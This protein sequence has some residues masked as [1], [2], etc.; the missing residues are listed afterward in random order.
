V[1]SLEGHGF[2]TRQDHGSTGNSGRASR[3]SMCCVERVRRANCGSNW[4][5]VKNPCRM[6]LSLLARVNSKGGICS[7]LSVHIQRQ[8]ALIGATLLLSASKP[9][10]SGHWEFDSGQSEVAQNVSMKGG[11]LRITHNEPNITIAMFGPDGT[12][13]YTLNFVTNGKPVTNTF[14]VPQVSVTQWKGDKLV[15]T[16]NPENKEAPPPAPGVPRRQMA[17]SPFEWTWSIGPGGKTLVNEVHMTSGREERGEKWV[18]VR[19][20]GK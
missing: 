2:R 6:G 4:S 17:T 7:L 9:N 12:A 20:K 13:S 1:E 8:K 19:R 10:F 15:I 5:G 3:R 14:G 11:R 18:F 16:W